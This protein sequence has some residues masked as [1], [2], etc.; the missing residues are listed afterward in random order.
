MQI[1]GFFFFWPFFNEITEEIFLS[2]F[3]SFFFFIKT[4]DANKGLEELDCEF[5]NPEVDKDIAVDCQVRMVF[6]F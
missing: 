5:M 6:C 3:L 4:K 1:K 2:F